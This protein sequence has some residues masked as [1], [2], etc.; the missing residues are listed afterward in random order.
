MF[1]IV[2]SMLQKQAYPLTLSVYKK[3]YDDGYILDKAAQGGI[4]GCAE[5]EV[6]VAMF[7]IIVLESFHQICPQPNTS[8]HSG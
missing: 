6:P 2:C 4:G 8:P 7:A 5:V 1:H 3:V